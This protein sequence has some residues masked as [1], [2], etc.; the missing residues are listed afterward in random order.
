MR[1]RKGMK[2]SVHGGTWTGV[3]VG[4]DTA[5]DRGHSLVRQDFVHGLPRHLKVSFLST[6]TDSSQV[7]FQA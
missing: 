4:N 2:G 6:H 1:L 7:S 3:G 5:G